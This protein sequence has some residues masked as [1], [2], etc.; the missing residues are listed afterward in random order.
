MNKEQLKESL[1]NWVKNNYNLNNYKV[2]E[3]LEH[4]YYVADNAL[5]KLQT[6]ITM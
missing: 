4:T 2:K 6:K 1:H 3:K 5:N